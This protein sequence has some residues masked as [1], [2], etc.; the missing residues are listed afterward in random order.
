VAAVNEGKVRTD[1]ASEETLNDLELRCINS[2]AQDFATI[3][4]SENGP[5]RSQSSA[6]LH[7]LIE[8]VQEHVNTA[9]PPSPP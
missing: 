7:K 3:D 1:E 6:F 5:L 9:T 2:L 4:T 8:K